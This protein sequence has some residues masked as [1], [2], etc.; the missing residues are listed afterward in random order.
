[1]A[2]A[3]QVEIPSS[4]EIWGSLRPE[5]LKE[6][7]SKAVISAARAAVVNIGNMVET[8]LDLAARAGKLVSRLDPSGLVYEFDGYQEVYDELMDD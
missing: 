7:V 2:V 4:P 1:M 3:V 6:V 8:S 5:S